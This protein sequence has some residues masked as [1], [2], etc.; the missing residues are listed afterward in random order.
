MML[1]DFAEE[2]SLESSG[3]FT[4]SLDKAGEKLAQYRLHN[5]GLFVL[6]LVAAAVTGG[7]SDFAVETRENITSFRFNAKSELEEEQIERLFAYILE[8][9]APAYVRELALAVHGAR[10]LPGRPTITLSVTTST[11]SKELVLTESGHQLVEA[12][13]RNRGVLLELKYPQQGSWSRMFSRQSNRSDDILRHLFHF[14]RFAPLSMSNNGQAKGTR[15]TAGVYNS[16]VFAWSYLKGEHPLKAVTAERR[17]DLMISRKS[18]SPIASSMVLTLVDAQHSR[19]EGVLLIS[20]GVTFHRSADVLGFPLARAVVTADHLE[21]NL[22]QSDLVETEEFHILMATVREQ[23]E[24]LI[25]ET[26]STPPAKWSA[27]TSRRFL[28]SLALKYPESKPAPIPVEAFRRVSNLE[29]QC[30]TPE[31]QAG[32][33]TFWRELCQKDPATAARFRGQLVD[34]FKS[35]ARRKIAYEVWAVAA[36]NLHYL[37]ELEDR[38]SDALQVVLWA[39]AENDNA[40]KALLTQELPGYTP[41]LAFLLGWLDTLEENSPTAWLFRFQ[42]AVEE[43]NLASADV[44]AEHLKGTEGTPL[45]YLWLG[46]YEVYRMRYSEASRLW[47][48]ALGLLSSQE[49]ESWAQPLWRELSGKVTFVDQVRW[50][51]RRSIEEMQRSVLTSLSLHNERGQ[52]YGF[53]PLAWAEQVWIYHIEGH[54]DKARTLFVQKFLSSRVDHNTLRLEPL[55]AY[56]TTLSFFG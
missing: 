2:G 12:V 37:S 16:S 21:K 17:F 27:E 54:S 41:T 14:C 30:Q 43:G 5:P 6:N 36:R 3:V 29:Q 35:E 56:G 44:L 19:D 23:V 46:W 11:L 38:P 48:R 53:G 18:Q 51:A 22:S 9:S 32:Q 55:N 13:P 52:V 45:L 10:S 42:R 34:F 24:D 50:R 47:D 20:R 8:P 33:I 49:R 25:L 15:V 26:C 28:N 1:A 39:L 7:A 40:G 31:E 4:L